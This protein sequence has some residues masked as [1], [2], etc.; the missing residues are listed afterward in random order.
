MAMQAIMK[1]LRSLRSS[2]LTRDKNE[3]MGLLKQLHISGERFWA[4]LNSDLQADTRDLTKEIKSSPAE[5]IALYAT[6]RLAIA[7]R[8]KALIDERVEMLGDY[9]IAYVANVWRP[10]E[11]EFERLMTHYSKDLDILSAKDAVLQVQISDRSIETVAVNVGLMFS[12]DLIPDFE[13]QL[14]DTRNNQR[15]LASMLLHSEPAVSVVSVEL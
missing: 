12:K 6:H 1:E 14:V 13:H 7:D 15:T 5:G 2:E 11:C 10:F 9:M 4:K 3:T 8:M